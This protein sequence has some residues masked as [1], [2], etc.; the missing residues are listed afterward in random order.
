MSRAK[1]RSECFSSILFV[2]LERRRA[3]VTVFSTLSLPERSEA[4]EIHITYS[5]ESGAD[6][7]FCLDVPLRFLSSLP[8]P[9]SVNNFFFLTPWCKVRCFSSP[10]PSS[11]S[12]AHVLQFLLVLILPLFLGDHS[13]PIGSLQ[14]ASPLS[15][16]FRGAAAL[17]PLSM[18][19]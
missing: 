11:S 2:E 17:L 16:S 9:S 5:A 18:K 13:P 3:R 8:L 4:A 14:P 19:Q 7:K 15:I 6:Q 12:P 10:S 1:L